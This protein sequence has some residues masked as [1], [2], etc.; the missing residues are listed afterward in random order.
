MSDINFLISRDRCFCRA[1]IMPFSKFITERV[2]TMNNK[3]LELIQSRIGYTF[4]NADLLQQAFTRKSYA[5][6]NGGEDNEV[7][8]FIGDKV[9]DIIIVKF[10]IEK[11]GY[12]ASDCDDYDKNSDYNDFCC[13]YSEGRL[14]ELKKKLVE[15]KTLAE[16]I[17]RLK[18]VDYL[19]LGKGDQ[20]NKVF[21]EASVKEDLFEAIIGAVTIDSNWN[22]N[23]IRSV[24]EY[25]LEPDTYLNN[26]EE[27]YV[28]LIQK[29][30]LKRNGKLPWIKVDNATYQDVYYRFR[31]SNVVFSTTKIDKRDP[32]N[33]IINFQ[34]YPKTHFKCELHLIAMRFI[35]FGRSKN[36]A[37]KDV[38]KLAYDYLEKND[39]L[40]SIQDEIDNP[41]KDDAVNQLEILARRGYFSIPTYNFEQKYADNGNPIWICECHIKEYDTY[42]DSESSTKKDA[43]K[44]A[45]FEMLEFVL[46]EEE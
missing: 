38:C 43:K 15:K 5:K 28:E 3:D 26:K 24:V 27:N 41:N 11:F 44:S 37:R 31:A 2:F 21:E 30:S 29:W 7:L 19:I 32:N 4:H 17:D 6:E 1:I 25:M 35:G 10:L 36:D 12:L 20:K 34:E 22:W 9:L 46:N 39:L 23:E 8:E 16:R 42:C 33:F 40:F 18:F 13:E 45:A 14:T